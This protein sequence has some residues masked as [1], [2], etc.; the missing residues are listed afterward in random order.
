MAYPTLS[1]YAIN[2][3]VVIVASIQMACTSS[4]LIHSSSLQPSNFDKNIYA[5]I[6]IGTSRLTPDVSST[7]LLDVNDRVEPAGQLTLGADVTKTLSMEIHSADLG[8][9]GFSPA[10][11]AD[12]G[13]TAGRYNYHMSGISALA[14]LGGNRAN[15]KRYGFTGYGR[16]GLV[17]VHNSTSGNLDFQRGDS[18]GL[19]LGAGVEYALLNG[20]GVRAELMAA[21]KDIKYGQIGVTYRLGLNRSE[22]SVAA[23]KKPEPENNISEIP[24]EIFSA[25]VPIAKPMRQIPHVERMADISD[26]INFASNSDKLSNSAKIILDEF[27]ERLAPYS[28]ARISLSAHTDGSGPYDY[29]QKL[30]SRRALAVRQ[31][32]TGRGIDPAAIKTSAAGETIPL[33]SNSTANGRYTNRRVELTASNLFRRSVGQ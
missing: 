19:L 2:W 12:G 32:L 20:L 30:S 25:E 9:A 6:G 10:G 33:Q 7:P 15:H 8:S 31:H 21:D 5:V 23:A 4:P 26:V 16:L 24:K 18:N 27:A 14:Y 22:P 28:D 29:N 11:V 17:S 1:R 13:V 3:C